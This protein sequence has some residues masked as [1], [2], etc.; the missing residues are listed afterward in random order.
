MICWIVKDG[1]VYVDEYYLTK[2]YEI[3]ETNLFYDVDKNDKPRRI[4]VW[5]AKERKKI[6]G[7]IEFP[8]DHQRPYYIPFFITEERPGWHQP[9]FG[10]ILQPQNIIANSS[11]DLLL[12]NAFYSHIPLIRANPGSS[13]A[14]QLLSKSWRIG[15]PLIAEKGE[16]EKFDL[17]TGNLND[18]MTLTKFNEHLGDD[19]TGVGSPGLSGKADPVDPDAPARKTMALIRETNI[20]IKDYITNNV[21]LNKYIKVNI[22]FPSKTPF[23]SDQICQIIVVSC[24]FSYR[25]SKTLT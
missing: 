19:T 15:D 18:L 23:I 14:S 7:A 24:Y 6:L 3:F 17:K 11:V 16:V 13:I 21:G 9:G 2:D 1:Q 20:S 8:F 4:V 22:I 12:D 10:R 5:Y 25:A